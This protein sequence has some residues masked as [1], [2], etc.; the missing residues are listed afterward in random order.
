MGDVLASPDRS[1]TLQH[2]SAEYEDSPFD[3]RPAP[4]TKVTYAGR[5]KVRSVASLAIPRRI[6]ALL[7]SRESEIA[8]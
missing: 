8:Q 2:G 6:H 4:I 3:R 1:D 5:Q 7:V